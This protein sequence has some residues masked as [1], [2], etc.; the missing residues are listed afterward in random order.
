METSYTVLKAYYEQERREGNPMP[1]HI[2]FVRYLVDK[3]GFVD[4]FDL[5]AI[6]QFYSEIFL[7]FNM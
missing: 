4:Q 6:D 1:T 3:Y 7:T 2:D 5:D